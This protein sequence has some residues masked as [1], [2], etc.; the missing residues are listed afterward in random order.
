MSNLPVVTSQAQILKMEVWVT[1]RNGTSTQ[2]RQ[3]VT[4]MD[5]G[6]PQPY[7]KNILPLTPQPYPY[8]DANN[9]YRNIINNPG[10]RNST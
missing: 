5:L 1:N 4:L 7:N 3:V 8:N 10:S 6:E 9:E 2:A